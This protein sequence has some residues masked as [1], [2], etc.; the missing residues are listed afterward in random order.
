MTDDNGVGLEDEETSVDSVL[1][2]DAA[3]VGVLKARD[4][5]HGELPMVLQLHASQFKELGG[6]TPTPRPKLTRWTRFKRWFR[7]VTSF[8]H[9][10]RRA[11]ERGWDD[12]A[13]DLDE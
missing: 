5:F 8:L 7:K 12:C 10:F 6:G 4:A 2:D 9:P 13:G 11:Y 3:F 1:S